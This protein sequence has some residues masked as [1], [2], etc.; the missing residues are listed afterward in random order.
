VD[1]S[2]E[3]GASIEEPEGVIEKEVEGRESDAESEE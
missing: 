3:A 2:L 1:N